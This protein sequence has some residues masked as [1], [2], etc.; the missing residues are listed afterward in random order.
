MV[1]HW[2]PFCVYRARG[3]GGH[4]I[5]PQFARNPVRSS[6]PIRHAPPNPSFRR[7][8]GPTV[9]ADPAIRAAMTLFATM[10]LGVR[11]VD[12]RSDE[13]GSPIKRGRE[14]GWIMMGLAYHDAQRPP[15]RPPIVISA[16]A[17]NPR[18]RR[19]WRYR[20]AMTR[21]AT[22]GPG[23]RRDDGGGK[24]GESGGRMPDEA[25][26]ANDLSPKPY[27]APPRTPQPP[28]ANVRRST[29]P[30][31]ILSKASLLAA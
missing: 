19:T 12:G 31:R 5:E 3:K 16:N 15:L 23:V 10:G 13:W 8:P 2:R 9:T 14:L 30:K 4:R 29:Q 6:K 1:I 25:R 17:G 20:A 11:R 22:M 27:R 7:T 24:R 18:L 21:S 28:N 26:R